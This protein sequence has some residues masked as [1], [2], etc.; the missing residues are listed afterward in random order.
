MSADSKTPISALADEQKHSCFTNRRKVKKEHI[1][2][3]NKLE[4]S[5]KNTKHKIESLTVSLD[6]S[7]GIGFL[8]TE[9][10]K[11]SE[12]QKAMENSDERKKAHNSFVAELGTI[13]A[14]IANK[15]E[16]QNSGRNNVQLCLP[17]DS[18][19]SRGLDRG[20]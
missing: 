19:N 3:I 8:H 18:I 5:L 12:N 16:S 6:G 9:N 10:D 2:K 1:R 11:P 20:S 7:D 14:D 17:W 15:N 4:Q 13:C